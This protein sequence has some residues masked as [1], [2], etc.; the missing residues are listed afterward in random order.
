MITLLKLLHILAFTAG[1][2][3]GLANLLVLRAAMAADADAAKILRGI[4]PRIATMSFHAVILLW[5]T[6]PLLLWLAYSGGA[7]LAPLF[8]LKML[9]VVLLTVVSVTGRITI[10]RIKAGK[11]ARFAPHMPKIAMLGSLFGVSTIVLA[12]LAF[13]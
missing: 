5:I 2:G 9:S 11:P 6:G 13:S 4:M 10:S 1:V 8:H 12:V 3:G 7:G